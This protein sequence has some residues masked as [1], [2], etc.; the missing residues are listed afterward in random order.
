MIAFNW[1]NRGVNETIGKNGFSV[2]WQGEIKVKSSGSYKLYSEPINGNAKVW[3]NNE[4]VLSGGSSETGII[5]LSA[6]S[7]YKIQVEY[8]HNN[9]DAGMFLRWSSSTPKNVIPT[10]SLIPDTEILNTSNDIENFIPHHLYL[11][12]NYP[13]PFNPTT[14]INF[15][16]PSSGHVRLSVFNMLGQEV[17]RLINEQLGA[18]FHSLSF[19][20]AGYSSGVYI[21]RLIYKEHILTKKLLLV[22]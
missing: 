22:K 13:N 2:R 3:L 9:G 4:Q 7:T 12:Q 17:E 11:A 1:G 15:N 18:G 14:Q 5:S 10:N 19:N 16:L 6:N 20:A 8:S 21:Y